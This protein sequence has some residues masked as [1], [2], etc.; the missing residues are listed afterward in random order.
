MSDKSAS[1]DQKYT[2]TLEV[3]N[4]KFDGSARSKKTAKL[5]CAINTINGLQEAGVMLEAQLE[6]AK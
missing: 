1:M 5:N 2:Y 3:E 6:M 4:M